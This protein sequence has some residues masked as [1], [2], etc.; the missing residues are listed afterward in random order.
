MWM[1]Y[2][3]KDSVRALKSVFSNNVPDLENITIIDVVFETFT[4]NLHLELF[5]KELPK[6]WREKGYNCVTFKL[7]FN[8]LCYFY[9]DLNLLQSHIFLVSITEYFHE[10]KH[11]II[12]NATGDVVLDFL[13]EN[14]YTID[15]KGKTSGG[16]S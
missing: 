6:R 16:L 3:D 14:I 8:V 15:F 1:D 2:I 12:K 5:S 4:L 10:K 11:I 13:A 7:C 9:T